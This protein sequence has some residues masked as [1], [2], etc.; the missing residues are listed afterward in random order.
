MLS[1]AAC[2]FQWGVSKIGAG[3]VG[4]REGAELESVVRRYGRG[5]HVQYSDALLFSRGPLHASDAGAVTDNEGNALTWDGRLD[6]RAELAR[7]LPEGLS[8]EVADEV[9]VLAACKRWPITRALA[10]LMGDWALCF[11]CGRSQHVYLARDFAGT[12]PLYYAEVREEV[13]WCSELEPLLE[14]TGPAKLNERYLAGLF[15]FGPD[16]A[17][18]PFNE[19]RAVPPGHLVSVGPDG[20]RCEPFWVWDESRSVRYRRD[21]EYEEHFRTLLAGGVKDRLREGSRN[22]AFLSGGLDSSTIVCMA[23]RLSLQGDVDGHVDTVTYVYDESD[24]GERYYVAE[25]ERQR[26]RPTQYLD[27][28]LHLPFTE[29]DS[30]QPALPTVLSAS[31][32]L[33]K[34]QNRVTGTNCRALLCGTGGDELLGNTRKGEQAL[35]QLI[36]SGAI[37]RFGRDLSAWSFALRRPRV[38]LIRD[39]LK[40][41]TAGRVRPFSHGA[42][43]WL[44]PRF[45]RMIREESANPAMPAH[46]VLPP[47]LWSA[48]A[49]VAQHQYRHWGSGDFTYP[50]LDRRLVEFC[51]AVPI[52]QLIRPGETRSLMRRSL[53]GLV[54]ERILNRRSKNLPGRY[55]G[56][57]IEREW[58]RLIKQFTSPLSARLGFILPEAIQ[59]SLLRARHGVESQLGPLLVAITLESWLDAAVG[60]GWIRTVGEEF[61][62]FR[63]SAADDGPFRKER[64]LNHGLFLPGTG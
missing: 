61:D 15:S 49:T 26:G 53:R 8:R 12:R 16:P 24:R 48:I 20:V 60:R 34:E 36:R 62:D 35:A 14:F 42:P 4:T 55:I 32:A 37:R 63:P 21:E 45:L 27:A 47:G 23:D 41:L 64:R 40:R 51:L 44:H 31:S 57:G 54:P 33:V 10:K 18:S 2:A 1:S 43:V 7:V 46:D 39:T 29:S 28:F 6:D 30:P 38:H 17:L 3:Q 52:D 58:M 5:T 22:W 13:R 59:A 11:R 25:I 50:F 19:I 9:A 56:L